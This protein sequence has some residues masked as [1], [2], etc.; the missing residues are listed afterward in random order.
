MNHLIQ[1]KSPKPVDKSTSQ[2]YIRLNEK[3][4]WI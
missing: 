1:K 2:M 4:T 3:K